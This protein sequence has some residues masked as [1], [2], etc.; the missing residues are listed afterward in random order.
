MVFYDFEVK[1]SNLPDFSRGFAVFQ[2]VAHLKSI[3]QFPNNSK[4]SGGGGFNFLSILDD[5][6]KNTDC[7]NANKNQ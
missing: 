6:N 4:I 1:I 7:Q 2:K 3:K 5:F